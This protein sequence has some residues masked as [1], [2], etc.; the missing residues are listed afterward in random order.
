[1]KNKFKRSKL[2]LINDIKNKKKKKNRI[3]QNFI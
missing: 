2:I 1:M 3:L